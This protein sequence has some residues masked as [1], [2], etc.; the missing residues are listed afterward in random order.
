MFRTSI[1]FPISNS[2]F[3]TKTFLEST[4]W[5]GIAT[6]FVQDLATYSAA[7]AA[8]LVT[9]WGFCVIN[10][11]N[12]AFQSNLKRQEKELEDKRCGW[13]R[14]W[15]SS[16][17]GGGAENNNGGWGGG[18]GGGNVD[19]LGGEVGGEVVANIEPVDDDRGIQAGGEGAHLQDVDPDVDTGVAHVGEVGNT[20]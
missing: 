17:R 3:N 1:S 13:G 9:Y 16:E 14:G 5:E 20:Q 7:S 15:G 2:S 6:H 12:L 8:L 11:G 4:F 19:A 18:W 10:R